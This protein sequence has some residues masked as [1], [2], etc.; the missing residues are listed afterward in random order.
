MAEVDQDFEQMLGD[1]VTTAMKRAMTLEA[2]A[3]KARIPNASKP[4][5]PAIDQESDLRP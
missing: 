1:K 5:T 3:G 4:Q 2:A